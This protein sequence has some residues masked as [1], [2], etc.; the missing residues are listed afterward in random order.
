M[1]K[2]LVHLKIGTSEMYKRFG[3]SQICVHMRCTKVTS[4][5]YVH[6]FDEMCKMYSE[7]C[8]TSL[9]NPLLIIRHIWHIWHIWAH[10]GGYLVGNLTVPSKNVQYV[11]Y[12]QARNCS[13]CNQHFIYVQY[14][15]NVRTYCTYI[16]CWLHHEQ[17]L[18]C[19]YYTSRTYCIYCTFLGGILYQTSL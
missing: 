19:K 15:Q 13:W 8:G 4:D 6:V 16:K 12:L 9:P 14:L 7:M 3:T 5:R 11:Q 18:A 1:Y 10:L 17:F 2:S